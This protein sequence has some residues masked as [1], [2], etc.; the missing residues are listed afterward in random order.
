MLRT[1]LKSKLHRAAITDANVNYEGS[2]TIPT[3]LM[4]KVDLWEGEKVLVTSITSGARLETYVIPAP[5]GSGQ[6]II[7]GAAAH[8]ISTGHRVTIMAW[9]HSETP[10]IP[11]RVLLN[12]RNEIVNETVL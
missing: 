10:I 4:E 11:K 12:E 6:I 2:I 1:S 8:L 7:N 5:S 9:G 3:D